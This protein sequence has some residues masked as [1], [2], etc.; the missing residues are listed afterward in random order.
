MV[1][2]LRANKETTPTSR[3]TSLG[4]G[5]MNGMGGKILFDN[6][7]ILV[8]LIQ[9]AMHIW[10]QPSHISEL[11]EKFLSRT[12]NMGKKKRKFVRKLYS[13]GLH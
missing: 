5:G 9:Y 1:R 12:V 2:W 4:Y 7:M 3:L 13:T 6:G 8:I 11:M 10:L